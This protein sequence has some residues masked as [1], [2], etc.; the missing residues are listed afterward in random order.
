MD[1][2]EAYQELDYEALQ[3][4]LYEQQARREELYA[5]NCVQEYFEV[6]RRI[7]ALHMLHMINVEGDT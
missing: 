4:E 2:P 7:N 6:G 3:A 1:S 5:A